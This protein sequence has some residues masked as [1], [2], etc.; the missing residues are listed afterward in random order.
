MDI[1]GYDGS[2]GGVHDV[3]WSTQHCCLFLLFLAMQL[4]VLVRTPCRAMSH[5]R[6]S[7]ESSNECDTTHT[8]VVRTSAQAVCILYN[9]APDLIYLYN[10]HRGHASN[11]YVPETSTGQR[12][13]GDFNLPFK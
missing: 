3:W 1:P 12:K 7:G 8:W 2:Y 11:T 6:V 5:C 9:F 13:M 10:M 4:D